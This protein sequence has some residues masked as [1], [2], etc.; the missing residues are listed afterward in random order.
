MKKL[1]KEILKKVERDMKLK[2]R[3]L[4]KELFD[5]I[6]H[7]S[8]EEKFL[9][10][11]GKFQNIDGGFGNGLEPDVRLP[12]SSATATSIALEHLSKFEANEGAL[13]M[14][15][16]AINYLENSYIRERKGWYAVGK[17]VNDHPHAPW[18]HYD[19]GLK[20][21]ALD[22]HWGNPS[23]AILAYL[24]KYAHFVEKINIE[25]IKLKATKNIMSVDKFESFHEL[26][27][28]CTLAEYSDKD[29]L[30]T[31]EQKLKI[32]I[33]Y[34]VSKDESRWYT[35]YDATPL[36]F[37][38]K[39]ECRFGVSNA[40]VDRN[41]DK[42]IERLNNEVLLNP[43]WDLNHTL[44]NNDMKGVRDEWLGVL[45]MKAL[46]QLLRWDRIQG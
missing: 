29:F 16:K 34:L 27:C 3:Q 45:T 40:L 26:F 35:S 31:F 25:A 15:K 13:V 23:A 6:I 11:L 1:S 12:N 2:A 22:K 28:Y 30:D 44:Y 7:N 18:W 32:G 37:V 20:M 21:T 39:P 17:E 43:H 8:N 9:A 5:V 36:N 38:N 42:L 4:E 24:I 33:D 46:E 19:E 41:L 14:I 10:E